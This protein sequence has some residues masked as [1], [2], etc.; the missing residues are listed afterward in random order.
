VNITTLLID[1]LN[2]T[3]DAGEAAIPAPD[4]PAEAP[5]DAPEGPAPETDATGASD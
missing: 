2:A 3:G 4:A 1:R 5:A